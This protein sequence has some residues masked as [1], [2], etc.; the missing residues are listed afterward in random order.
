MYPK[1]TNASL[2]DKVVYSLGVI[3]VVLI[4]FMVGLSRVALGVHSFNQ[5]LY[6]W[7]Y[8]LWLAF[9]LFRFV[10][11]ALRDHIRALLEYRSPIKQYLSY[12]VTLAVLIWF[13]VNIVSLLNYLLA[14]RDFIVPPP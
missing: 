14:K 9:F 13:T 4:I 6:G 1:R 12:Y 10:R 8:G 11:P 3:L 5:V 2:L 7:S